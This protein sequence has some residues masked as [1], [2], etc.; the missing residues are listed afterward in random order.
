MK[1]LSLTVKRHRLFYL[2]GSY[3]R[4][5]AGWA[6]ATGRFLVSVRLVYA[7]LLLA[8]NIYM[9]TRNHIS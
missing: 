1:W 3:A 7:S 4:E 6:D 2:A 5:V 9:K 8:A